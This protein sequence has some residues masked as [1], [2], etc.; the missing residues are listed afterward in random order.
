MFPGSSMVATGA[1][2]PI[3]NEMI[4]TLSTAEPFI[5]R[6]ETTLF[7]AAFV[8]ELTTARSFA[9]PS[10]RVVKDERRSDQCNFGISNQHSTLN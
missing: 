1:T 2:P 4:R 10:T 5:N 3:W 9:S 7:L 6:A 8:S